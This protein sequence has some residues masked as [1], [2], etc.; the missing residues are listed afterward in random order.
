MVVFIQSAKE[1]NPTSSGERFSDPAVDPGKMTL[2]DSD[3]GEMTLML[4]LERRKARD[5]TEAY[6]FP[7]TLTHKHG[8]S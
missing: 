7:S 5:I 6:L 4:I 8:S 2:M 3:P 1:N